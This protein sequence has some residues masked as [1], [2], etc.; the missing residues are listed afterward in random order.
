MGATIKHLSADGGI[1]VADKNWPDAKAGD[2]QTAEKFFIENNGDRELLSLV[3][4]IVPVGV[5]DGDDQ[6]RI[7]L[8][9]ATVIPP[10]LV[11]PTLTGPAAGGVWA[12]TGLKLYRI[13]ALN[14]TG[15]TTG[16]VEASVNVDDTTKKVTL[17][18]EI[19]PG[20]TGYRIYRTIT[21]GV[22]TTPAL[23]IV[24]GSGTTDT[25]IDGGEVLV[26]GALPADNTTAGPSPAYGTPPVLGAGPISVGDLEIGQQ[27]VY[28]VNRVIPAGTAEA[29][30][31]RLAQ[32]DFDE[33]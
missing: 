32:I 12:S 15:E 11:V 9:T 6:L 28:W 29:G 18:W 13:T 5:N 8:D 19:V 21:P 25:F 22:Y 23:R 16:S 7:A 2:I 33:T 14:A 31:P 26:A 17:T 4:T 27:F 20:A 30:N 10:F 3:G 24:I 1:Q